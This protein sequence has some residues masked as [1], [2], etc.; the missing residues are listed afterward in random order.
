M[1]KAK[2]RLTGAAVGGL[3]VV[4]GT[5]MVML[6]PSASAATQ[7]AKINM[8]CAVPPDF[9]GET[10]A[11]FDFSI[12]VPEKTPRGGTAAL[13][14]TMGATP[15]KIGYDVDIPD[16]KF[17]VGFEGTA[18][19]G[20]TGAVTIAGEGPIPPIKKDVPITLPQYDATVVVPAGAT[21]DVVVDISKM[22]ITA[23]IDPIPCTVNGPGKLL[24]IPVD[25][26]ATASPSP[27]ATSSSTASASPSATAST[28]KPPA[29]QG[30]PNGKE[31]DVEYKCVTTGSPIPIPETTPTY[32]IK[33]IVPSTATK[34]DKVAISAKYKDD[35]IG[36]TPDIPN[37]PSVTLRYT[38]SLDITVK[39]GETKSTVTVVGKEMET[40][41]AKG[42]KLYADGP[43][44]GEFTVWGGGDFE[45]SPGEMRQVS[46]PPSLPNVKTSTICSVTKTVVSATLKAEGDK[47]TPDPTLTQTPSGSADTKGN[48]GGDT[49]GDSDGDTSGDTTSKGGTSGGLA[50]TGSSGGG[51]TAFA[52]AAGTAVL[53]AIALMLFVPYRRRM[54]GQV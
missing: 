43:L 14:I 22:T 49:D 53:A 6:A 32:S 7:T 34:G 40:K 5:G 17:Q 30:P 42:S 52:M 50:E 28:S 35:V 33:I 19:G 2:T 13:K 9:G 23:V 4:G 39:Q 46:S 10:T 36:T 1:S 27:T 45:F 29:T 51:L 8:T 24:T 11:D 12:E 48:T 31:V 18:S 3:L 15:I 54:R 16:L 44:T 47:G 26:G 38:P 20:A 25:V 21:D 37:L 41:P